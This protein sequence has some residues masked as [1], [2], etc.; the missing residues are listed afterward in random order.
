MY[1]LARAATATHPLARSV[2]L[3]FL[4][5]RRNVISTV[6][7]TAMDHPVTWG[8]AVTRSS[9]HNGILETCRLSNCPRSVSEAPLSRN[10]RRAPALM[11]QRQRSRVI[12][13]G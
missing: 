5:N 7:T 6:V 10:W 2:H 9:R 11:R 1:P 4:L 8:R 13:F 3:V 12:Q